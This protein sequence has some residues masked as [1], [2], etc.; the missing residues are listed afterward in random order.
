MND[1]IAVEKVTGL[2]SSSTE[3]IGCGQTA[4]LTWSSKGATKTELDGASVSASGD[5][6]V[7]PKQTTDYKFTAIGPGGVYTADS[8]VNVD[9]S[10]QAS[11]SVSPGEVHYNSG[12]PATMATLT[13]SAPNA[14]SVTLDQ[15]G[16]VGPSGSREVPV[17]PTQTSSG[18]IYQTVT[19]TLHASN[20][21]GGSEIRTATLHIT[22]GVLQGA[23]NGASPETDLATLRSVYFP[24]NWP[25][26]QD[27][28]VGLVASQRERLDINASDVKQY[29][30]LRP[31]AKLILDGYA[32]ERGSLEYNQALSQRRADDVKN[33]LIEQGVPADKIETRAHG[34]TEGL[35]IKEVEDLAAEDPQITVEER[36]RLRHQIVLLRWA[37]NRRVDVKL[38]TGVTSQRFYPYESQDAKVLM[39]AKEPSASQVASLK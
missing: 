24:T 33:Y 5:E 27:P 1:H 22:G 39:D 12:A 19:Y 6:T 36:Q 20:A 4:H 3:Q 7:Q 15:I 25:T 21:C 16:S 29:L 31:E 38:S 14:D 13:W 17:T 32:D 2:F 26:Q 28:E 35:T 9:P 11:L 37:N 23:A 10:I 18:H 30:A 8:K 34:K